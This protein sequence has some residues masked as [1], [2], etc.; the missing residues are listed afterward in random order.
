M[1]INSETETVG[2]NQMWRDQ[3]STVNLDREETCGSWEENRA[4][5]KANNFSIRPFLR[6]GALPSSYRALTRTASCA[7]APSRTHLRARRAAPPLYHT[8]ALKR[9]GSMAAALEMAASR[10]AAKA[11]QIS[12][13]RQ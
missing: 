2:E 10:K 1:K 5:R 3:K 11:W 6:E 4:G 9:C 7:C 13:G 12:S 8:A